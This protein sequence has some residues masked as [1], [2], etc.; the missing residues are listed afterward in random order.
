MRDG[1]LL[2]AYKKTVRAI[3]LFELFLL[4]AYRRLRG[5]VEYE[6]KGSCGGCAKC[7]EAP[8]LAL[9]RLF[10]Y[11]PFLRRWFVRYQWHINRFR[12][13]RIDY[14]ARALVF[15]CAH[16][17]PHTRRCDSYDSR[18]GVCWDYP[19]FQLDQPWP[20]LFDECG[21]RAV[22]RRADA[23]ARALDATDLPPEQRERLKKRLHV[24]K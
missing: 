15:S 1:R 11:V 14:E 7:C 19:R 4:R 2:A 9:P 18:P 3:Y 8:T 6:L 23:L 20:E 16:F 13:V 12:L 24:L 5:Q 22:S 21:Y 10:W 17:D